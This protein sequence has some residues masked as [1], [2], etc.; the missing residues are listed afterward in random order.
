[1]VMPL[2]Y[3]QLVEKLA[4]EREEGNK[5]I[6]LEIASGQKVVTTVTPEDEVIGS[7]IVGTIQIPEQRYVTKSGRV[8]KSKPGRKP[9][10][11]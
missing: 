3:D 7:H 2:W 6:T 9:K 1:M 8:Y 4:R 11:K 10:V 5:G